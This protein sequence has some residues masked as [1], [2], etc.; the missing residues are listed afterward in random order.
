MLEVK[1]WEL[2]LS[3]L[4]V[5]GTT[6]NSSSDVSDVVDGEAGQ[7]E[8]EQ[9][10]IVFTCRTWRSHGCCL[11]SGAVSTGRIVLNDASLA[12]ENFQTMS[13]LSLP[14]LDDIVRRLKLIHIFEKRVKFLSSLLDGGKR[15]KRINM[16]QVQHRK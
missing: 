5:L 10:F 4:M 14:C 2:T 16:N 15:I 8:N 1:G 12:S 6:I 7:W 3:E 13:L 11:G 9:K